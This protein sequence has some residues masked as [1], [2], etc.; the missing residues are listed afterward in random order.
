MRYDD[1]INLAAVYRWL[2]AQILYAHFLVNLTFAT[3]INT[4]INWKLFN[5]YS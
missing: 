5:F 1:M 4:A 3:T 2:N